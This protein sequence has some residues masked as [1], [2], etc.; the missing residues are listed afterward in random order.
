RAASADRAG[1]AHRSGR[2]PTGAAA[3]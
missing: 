3:R 1:A 2:D